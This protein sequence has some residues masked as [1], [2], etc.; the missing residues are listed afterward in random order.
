MA[1][2]SQHKLGPTL[3]TPPGSGPAIA[4]RDLRASPNLV[5]VQGTMIEKCPTAGCW[6]MLRDSTGVIK[7]DTKD[8]EFTVTNVPLNSKITVAGIMTES[9]ERRII[10][11]GMRY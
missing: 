11:T 9:G 4:I 10:A 8:T 3:G 7:V 5:L 1:G 6:F 2:C